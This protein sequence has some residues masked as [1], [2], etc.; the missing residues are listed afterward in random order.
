LETEL[1]LPLV[2]RTTRSFQVTDAGRSLYQ[3]VHPVIRQLGDLQRSLSQENDE[4][5]GL[6]RITAPEDLG[7]WVLAPVISRLSSHYPRLEFDLNFTD[8]FVDLIRTQTDI[9]IRAGKLTDSSLRVKRIG[10][11]VF[12]FVASPR[13]LEKFGTPKRPKDLENHRC[14]V[15][16][17]GPTAQRDEWIVS[18]GAKKERVALRRVCSVNQKGVAVSLA[19]E[20]FGITLVPTPL[21]NEYLENGEL[22]EIL[23]GW[24]YE[25]TPIHLVYP[26]QKLVSLRVREV[27]RVLEERLRPIFKL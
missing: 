17:S 20:G 24:G 16:V 13:Y 15:A 2:L 1:K 14:I 25:A 23:Q 12:R 19:R 11:S 10:S 4:M 5:S 7:R 27:A 22:T 26:P 8:S 21:A 3:N 6:I 9:G 18:Q